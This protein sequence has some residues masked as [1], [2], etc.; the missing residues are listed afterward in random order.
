M[1][2]VESK[3]LPEK[4][5]HGV[6]IALLALLSVLFILP[7][8]HCL[9]ASFSEPLR[10]LSF[11]GLLLRPM[12][13][14][15]EGYKAVLH[16]R[17]LFT[18]YMNTLYYVLVG[19]TINVL[20]TAIGVYC[21]SRRNSLL[22]RPLTLALVFTMYANFGMVPAFLTVRDLGLYNSRWSLLLPTSVSTYNIIVMRTAFRSVPK[23]LEESAM[24]DGAGDLT[25]LVRILL[26]VTKAT[27]AVMVLL[28]AVGH[29]NSWFSASL[30]L[31]DRT[32]FPLQL[33]LREIL[34]SNSASADGSSIDGFLYL[35]E[36]IKY[37][38][39]V[40]ATVPILCIYPFVQKYFVSGIMLGAIKE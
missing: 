12:G 20:L 17:N 26:P 34:I 7:V 32:K 4:V 29:W 25:I 10:L 11:Q 33:F 9:M 40:V 28:Y 31:Q 27:L 18:G 19:T 21:L 2:M 36:A 38:T 24:L 16:N 23:S 1:S 37:S 30:Y 15:L 14:S 5:L 8:W 39:I 35:D 6:N 13:G 3:T 22:I